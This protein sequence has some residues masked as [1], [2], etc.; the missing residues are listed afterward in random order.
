MRECLGMTLQY[1]LEDKV[2]MIYQDILYNT[3]I[4]SVFKLSSMTDNF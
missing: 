1:K 4:L 3:G 2:Y